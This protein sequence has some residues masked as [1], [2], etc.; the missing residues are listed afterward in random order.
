MLSMI[1][2]ASA[3][4]AERVKIDRDYNEIFQA[5]VVSVGMVVPNFARPT[6]ITHVGDLEAAMFRARALTVIPTGGGSFV[7]WGAVGL[8]LPPYRA[9]YVQP[10]IMAHPMN[11]MLEAG[12]RITPNPEIAFDLQGAYNPVNGDAWGAAL[13]NLGDLRAVWDAENTLVF[14]NIGM[15]VDATGG[16]IFRLG[17][18]DFS[19]A[20]TFVTSL[21]DMSVDVLG[22]SGG[23]HCQYGCV[24]WNSTLPLGLRLPP[25]DYSDFG[26][27]Y[28]L[29][30]LPILWGSRTG[31]H[32]VELNLD[33]SQELPTS[34]RVTVDVGEGVYR[35][36][37]RTLTLA[38][39]L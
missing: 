37:V 29:H 35:T 3:L 4:A 17:A 31:V 25:A 24:L 21:Y 39:G 2:I 12:A 11:G 7:S 33:L 20:G 9:E 10:Y 1:T 6:L 18:M 27:T 16:P 22:T 30:W 38:I 26:V 23:P 14:A 8:R 28:K 32:A 36:P 13:I 34:W 19:I 5:R 15:G